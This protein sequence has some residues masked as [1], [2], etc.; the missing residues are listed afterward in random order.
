MARGSIVL[1]QGQNWYPTDFG[2]GI[3]LNGTTAEVPDI[4]D[5]MQQLSQINECGP[6][7][8]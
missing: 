8:V 1:F 2:N 3:F 6:G 4:R 7:E 5:N